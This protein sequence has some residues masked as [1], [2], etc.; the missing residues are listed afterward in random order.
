MPMLDERELS[1]IRDYVIRIL[2]ELLRKEPEI[3]A[4]IEG[5]LAQRFPRRDEFARLLDELRLL[6]ED[7]QQRFVL[8]REEMDR[9]FEQMDRNFT[10]LRE[11]MDRRFEQVD[12]RFEQVDQRF[13]QVDRRF[14]QMDQRFE[15]VDRRFEQVDQRLERVEGTLLEVRRD[16]ARVQHGQEMILKHMDGQEAWLRLVIGELRA[17]KGRTYEDLFAE[18]LRYGLKNPNIMPESLRLRQTLVDAEG[19]VFKRG[20]Q[21]EV[22]LIAEDDRLTVFEVKATA[23]PSDVDFFA[24]KVEL[25]ALQNPDKTIEGVFITLA[26]GQAVRQR[27]AKYGVRLVD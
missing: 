26:A 14:E 18:G 11:E 12:R 8:Q 19:R 10:L 7:M 24:L 1:Q 16:V 25:V 21:T 5:M 6:R 2:P 23:K 15:Q 20:F 3:A 9:R 13:E 4:T 27:C 17:E 22:D